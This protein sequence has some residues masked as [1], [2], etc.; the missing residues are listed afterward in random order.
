MSKAGLNFC[1][2]MRLQNPRPCHTCCETI[3]IPPCSKVKDVEDMSWFCSS[4]SP[5]VTSPYEQNILEPDVRQPINWRLFTNHKDSVRN[6]FIT[7]IPVCHNS[8][9]LFKLF[10]LLCDKIQTLKQKKKQTNKKTKQNR[11]KTPEDAVSLPIA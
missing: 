8:L 9:L 11:K 1:I 6:T 10:I 2:L 7:K 5:N 3:D 4:S